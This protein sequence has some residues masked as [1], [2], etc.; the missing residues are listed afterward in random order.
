MS[1][2]QQESSL[3]AHGIE[4]VARVHWN[5]SVP[6]LYEEAVRRR[7]ALIAE[8]GPLVCRTGQHTGRSPNDKFIVQESSSDQHVW[9][10]KVNRPIQA[11]HFDALREQ[12]L[13]YLEGKELF[14]QDCFAG[15]DPEYRLPIRIIT[16]Q[17]WHSL[18][19]RHMFIRGEK[20][21]RLRHAEPGFTVIDAPGFYASP[22]RHA[23]NSE[24]F[25]LVNL[26]RK[27][28]LI[29][30]T[31]YA[32]EIKK[33]IFTVMNYLLPRQDVM[34]MHCS[35]NVGP[36][37]DVALFFG[38][39]GTGKTTLSSDPERRLI[40]DDEHGWSDRGVFNLE[41]GCYAKMIRLSA[42][43]EPQIYS[44][45]QRF[46]TVLENVRM[47]AGSRRLDLDD[48][49]LTENTRG[50]YPLDF[51]DNAEPSGQA[52]HPRNIIML[53]ADAFGVLPPIARLAPAGAMYHF[54]SGYTAK[55]A[56]T[57]KGVT[58]PKA[59][60][61]TC[62]GAPFMVL[63]P[64]VY[65]RFLGDRIARH[66]VRV[67]LVNTGWTGGPPGVGSRM[68]IAHTRAMIRAA[69]SGGLHS[70]GY[71]R[72]A[73]FNLDVPVAC[74]DVPEQTLTPRSTWKDTAAYDAQASRLAKM[75]AD[76]FR[77]FEAEAAAEVKAAGP[78]G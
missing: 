25:I 41:G 74:P 21:E 35:A 23:T 32:G 4:N 19:A 73:I 71:R 66:D 58:E 11:A 8:G 34:S 6:A 46:G 76:N 16:E 56:G 10:G 31:S 13:R 24:V 40:G 52:G 9:W 38:L 75:F 47:D 53:T 2:Q 1:T 27:L 49:A 20:H 22:G 17:A 37:G 72:D 39:S 69:V 55:V 48:D 78:K 18:F 28:V 36:A 43:A 42:E 68:K 7:E 29:G 44:T 59:T 30:G 57:E 60:F 63:H 45:T 15:A 51:I 26:D 77:A 5:L 67:W 3:E 65:A 50:A 14:V 33:S 12:L 70:V 62:F 64:T 61:S 54:L